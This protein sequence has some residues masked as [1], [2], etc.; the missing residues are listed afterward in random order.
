M[1]HEDQTDLPATTPPATHSTPAGST[2]G[3]G[4]AATSG[5]PPD[6]AHLWRAAQRPRRG[7]R[8]RLT[9]EAVAEAAIAL[10]DVEGIAAVSMSRVAESLGV[11][12]MALYRYVA[13]KDDLLTLMADLA[14]GRPDP[15]PVLHGDR[16]R[17]GL[18][19]WCRDQL[20]LA[21]EH[22]WL[23]AT[24]AGLPPLGP[25]RIAWIERGL[26]T[27]EG[28]GLA[29]EEKTA[30]VG[31]IALHVLTEGQ[32]VAALTMRARAVTAGSAAGTG[33]DAGDDGGTADVDP[34]Q[35]PR[36]ATLEHP[37]LVDYG[38]LLRRLADPGE[39]PAITAALDAGAFD[40]D[41]QLEPV[42]E[43]GFGLRLLL[44]GVA[45]LVQRAAP[46]P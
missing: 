16:W 40:D 44:D 13:R 20:R 26:A 6:V 7:P 45:V 23:M 25:N 8:P 4:P 43:L 27:L 9:P 35:A 22:P 32:L 37:A 31:T 28:T 29:E 36:D 38:A 17:E 11:T 5:L 46:R 34:D 18:E 10:A 21:R 41:A 33:R 3:A 42:D 19:R 12:T 15:G 2:S 39:H 24:T 1:V 30:I 14:I